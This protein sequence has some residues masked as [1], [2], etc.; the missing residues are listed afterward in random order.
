MTIVC[1]YCRQFLYFAVGVVTFY[2]ISTSQI[3]QLYL[4]VQFSTL[5][6]FFV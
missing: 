6:L 1:S 3:S 4:V 2:Y 5:L